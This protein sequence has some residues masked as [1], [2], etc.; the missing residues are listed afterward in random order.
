MIEWNECSQ[1]QKMYTIKLG[2]RDIAIGQ[3][4]QRGR[5]LLHEGVEIMSGRGIREQVIPS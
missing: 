3:E 4:L 1:I 2:K 5:D